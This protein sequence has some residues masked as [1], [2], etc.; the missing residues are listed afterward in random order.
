MRPHDLQYAE[1]CLERWGAWVEGHL[2]Q[3]L[4]PQALQLWTL[5]HGTAGHR[6]LCASMPKRVWTVDLIVNRSPQPIKE[7]A[8]ARFVYILDDH[9]RQIPEELKISLLGISARLYHRR[10]SKV[11]RLVASN[12]NLP[13]DNTVCTGSLFDQ[14]GA[15]SLMQKIG[16]H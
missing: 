12:I 15:L 8:Y 9:N 14:H 16:S 6:I 2:D 5:G 4:Y 1:A 13:L 10:I 11:R 7:A 3:S